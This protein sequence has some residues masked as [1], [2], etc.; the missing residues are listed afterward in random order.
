[1]KSFILERS[2]NQKAARPGDW[3]MHGDVILFCEESLPQG[4]AEMNSVYDATLAD[5]EATHHYHRLFEGEFELKECQKTKARWLKVVEPCHLRHQE[6]KEI[7]VNPGVYRIDI[8]REYDPFEKLTRR[9][10]D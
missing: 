2:E 8:Q 5:G 1:M 9:V 10:I 6:H 4:F 3:I 7:T